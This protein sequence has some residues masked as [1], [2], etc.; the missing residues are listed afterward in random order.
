MAANNN[1]FEKS[2]V[3]K[4]V[5]LFD[6]AKQR[7]LKGEKVDKGDVARAAVSASLQ[8][9]QRQNQRLLAEQERDLQRELTQQREE[10][11]QTIEDIEAEL[12]EWS[13]QAQ[14]D[15]R[16]MM[17]EEEQKLFDYEMNFQKDELGRTILNEFQLLDYARLKA[18]NEEEFNDYAKRVELMLTL[19]QKTYEA[20]LRKLAH[21]EE[22]LTKIHSV[23]QEIEANKQIAQIAFETKKQV[24][25]A[26][27][28]M[29]RRLFEE[30]RKQAKVAAGFGV[31]SKI[32]S[33]GVGVAVG[34]L[35]ANPVA[36]VAAGAATETVLNT[37]RA[38]FS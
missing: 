20:A 8:E 12:E 36:G 29:Q 5:T 31:F 24:A 22:V 7:E 3:Q 1:P 6:Y 18:R 32:L 30:R 23:Y 21:A 15:L 27:A 9:Q 13:V 19:K 28:E 26:R 4:G 11:Q 33:A 10:A 2:A 37:G 17:S 35:T 16:D 14:L 38:L 34:V 25:A